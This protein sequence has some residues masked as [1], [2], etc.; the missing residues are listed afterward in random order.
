M[1][2]R[3][4]FVPTC[5]LSRPKQVICGSFLSDTEH[6]SESG[7]DKSTSNVPNTEFGLFV[8]IRSFMVK[9]YLFYQNLSGVENLLNFSQ[10]L[11][12]Y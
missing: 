7:S 5:L 9:Y 8:A 12:H 2:F 10:Y 1:V 11:I 6:K 3:N 4:L